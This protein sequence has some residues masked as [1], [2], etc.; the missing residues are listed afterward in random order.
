MTP[1][2]VISSLQEPDRQRRK[3]LLMDL[4]PPVW[5]GEYTIR[6]EEAKALFDAQYAEIK[7]DGWDH[8]MYTLL[9]RL[10][11]KAPPEPDLKD[12]ALLLV[13]HPQSSFRGDA[14]AYL[15]HAYPDEAPELIARFDNDPSWELQD[16]LAEHQ[17]RSDPRGAEARRLALLRRTELTHEAAETIPVNL[18]Y[19]IPEADLQDAFERYSR[20]ASGPRGTLYGDVVLAIL[21]RMRPRSS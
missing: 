20:L 13:A 7:Q 6:P 5:K 1:Q 19:A 18:A 4:I 16:V 21:H 11:R 17:A 8:G 10:I 3:E 12:Q 9:W 14:M 2:A 15:L